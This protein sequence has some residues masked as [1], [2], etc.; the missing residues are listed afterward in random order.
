MLVSRVS[1]L[2]K[3]SD[4]IPQRTQTLVDIL[5]LP[6]PFL[7]RNDAR[8]KTDV[9]PLATRQI[10]EIQRPLAPLACSTNVRARRAER[11]AVPDVSDANVD[12]GYAKGEYG[13]GARRTLVDECSCY[14]S[15]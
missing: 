10:D 11:I 1:T 13:M 9:Q 5:R 15:S 12:T 14:T 4:N 7:I 2:P 3:R 6:H 8:R